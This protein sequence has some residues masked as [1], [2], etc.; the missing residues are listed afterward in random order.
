[1]E[2][3]AVIDGYA[4]ACGMDRQLFKRV[5]K[6]KWMPMHAPTP[7]QDEVLGFMG[8]DGF[9]ETEIYAAGWEG[10]IWHY[11]GEKWFQ[12][13]SPTSLDLHAVCCA[14]DGVVYLC[15]S[16]GTFIKGRKD[17]WEVIGDPAF[18]KDLWDMHW[19]NDRLYAVTMYD[20]YELVGNDLK[21]VDT[22]DNM[23]SSCYRLSSAD[24]VMWSVGT[25][26]VFRY[27]GN[28]WEDVLERYS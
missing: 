5:A 19:F 24:G 10:E 3:V 15:G 27:D 23:P 1:M 14:G 2:D 12:I 13:D 28:K 17:K 20:I 8:M 11:N 25:R 22:G 4:Y 18:T 9:S 7:T 16:N 6:G 26:D 21:P